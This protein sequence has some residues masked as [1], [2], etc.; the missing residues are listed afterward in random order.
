VYN[1]QITDSPFSRTG[2]ESR[3]FKALTRAEGN[4]SFFV[5]L[6]RSNAQSSP[7]ARLIGILLLDF[8]DCGGCIS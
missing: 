3:P 6:A 5:L 2:W 7:L 4:I 1:R 8:D